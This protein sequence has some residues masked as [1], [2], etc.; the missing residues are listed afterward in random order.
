MLLRQPV[1]HIEMVTVVL[2]DGSR[3]RAQ[4]PPDIGEERILADEL[5]ALRRAA[6]A[7]PGPSSALAA[8]VT[9]VAVHVLSPRKLAWRVLDLPELQPD[10]RSLTVGTQAFEFDYL[11]SDKDARWTYTRLVNPRYL[12]T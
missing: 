5:G 12:E 2:G 4:A 1:D 8:A 6:D 11:L 9:T 10:Q 3:G 7:A